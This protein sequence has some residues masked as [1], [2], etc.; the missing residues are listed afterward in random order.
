[1]LPF[2]QFPMDNDEYVIYIVG[3]HVIATDCMDSW[4]FSILYL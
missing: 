4:P 2:A 1:M 3:T